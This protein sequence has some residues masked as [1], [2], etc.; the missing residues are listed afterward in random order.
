MAQ[1]ES[2]PVTVQAN[3]VHGRARRPHVQ[4]QQTHTIIHVIRALG[5]RAVMLH[6][7]TVRVRVTVQ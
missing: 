4:N 5:L 3:H 1:A 6:I 7:Q 2:P